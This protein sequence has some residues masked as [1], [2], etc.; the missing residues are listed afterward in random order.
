MTNFLPPGRSINC[1]SVP[2]AAGSFRRA[3]QALRVRRSAFVLVL[4]PCCLQKRRVNP[5]RSAFPE[6]HPRSGLRCSQGASFS[7]LRSATELPTTERQAS[8]GRTSASS[9]EALSSSSRLRQA[10]G[11]ASCPRIRPRGVMARP[12][13]YAK[14]CGWEYWRTAPSSNGTRVAM[15]AG[16]RDKGNGVNPRKKISVALCTERYKL[17]LLVQT[18]ILSLRLLT[19]H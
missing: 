14:R 19:F 6:L 3:H 1:Q 9:V 15:R 4:E 16:L 18:T 10:Y 17:Y 2:A 13:R 8:S 7:R 5:I 12:H 11:A